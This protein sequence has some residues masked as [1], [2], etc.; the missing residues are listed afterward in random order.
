MENFGLSKVF[1]SDFAS[2]MSDVFD[3]FNEKITTYFPDNSWLKPHYELKDNGD[4][5]EVTVKYDDA[6]DTVYVNSDKD[7]HLLSISVYEDWEKTNAISS[8]VYYGRFAMTVPDDCDLDSIEKSIDKYKNEMKISFKKL[9]KK[10]EKAVAENI[11]K[12]KN[13]KALYDQLLEKY[14]TKVQELENKSMNLRKENEELAKKLESIK[15]L[16]K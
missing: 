6:R 10:E 1:G 12:E 8:C 15:N 3:N 11:G 14:N 7:K 5:Y 16:F 13:Y 4:N 2:L 9:A